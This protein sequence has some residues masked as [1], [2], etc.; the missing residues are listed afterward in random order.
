MAHMGKELALGLCRGFYFVAGLE[1]VFLGGA[2][3]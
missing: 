1:I 3:L 2:D